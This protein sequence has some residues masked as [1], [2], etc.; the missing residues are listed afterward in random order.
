[1]LRALLDRLRGR[2]TPRLSGAWA[3]LSAEELARA[4]KTPS[5]YA[6]TFSGTLEA[7]Q[8]RLQAE[9]PWEWQ[10]RDSAWYGDYLLAL[11]PGLGRAEGLR[12]RMYEDE[13]APGQFTIELLWDPESGSLDAWEAAVQL[14]LHQILPG[15]GA[16][17]VRPTA[18]VD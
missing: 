13:P 18:T 11:G 10:L 15:V 8:A 3:R 9:G 7:L 16:E 17:K 2:R 14:V 12:V 6:F 1:M 4:S 5:A